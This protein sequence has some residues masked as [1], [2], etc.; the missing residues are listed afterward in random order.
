MFRAAGVIV[1]PFDI[2]P[3]AETAVTFPLTSFATT[4]YPHVVP[5]FAP[6]LVTVGADGVASRLRVIDP[7]RLPDRLAAWNV[8]VTSPSDPLP[9]PIVATVPRWVIPE[10]RALLGLEVT[11]LPNT[12]AI[13]L[14]LPLK[15]PFLEANKPDVPLRPNAEP[16]GVLKLPDTIAMVKTLLVSAHRTGPLPSEPKE[17]PD[18]YACL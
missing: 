11:L 2:V 17:N 14:P 8:P 3:S 5:V 12:P 10:S 6:V 4:L 15:A 9:T 13:M 18:I 7:R 16:L 1:V